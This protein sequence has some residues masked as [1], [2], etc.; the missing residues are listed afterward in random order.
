MVGPTGS[1]TVGS[2]IL[3]RCGGY[4]LALNYRIVGFFSRFCVSTGGIGLDART[5]NSDGQAPT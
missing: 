3:A 5:F 1:A 2:A 4:E